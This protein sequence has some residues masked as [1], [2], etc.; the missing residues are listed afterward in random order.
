MLS[1]MQT[2]WTVR[3]RTELHQRESTKNRNENPNQGGPVG[4]DEE[5]R[6]LKVNS[7][8]VAIVEEERWVGE[9]D[10]GF[11]WY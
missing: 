1:E 6:W 3:R 4:P 11:S 7:T 5:G 2:K 9:G 10:D 8:T